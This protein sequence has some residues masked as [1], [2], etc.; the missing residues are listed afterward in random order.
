MIFYGLFFTHWLIVPCADSFFP[1][2]RSSS[3][4]FLLLFPSKE[5]WLNILEGH[6]KNTSEY[7]K[8]IL[9]S[10]L[11]YCLVLIKR[12]RV[13]IILL[14]WNVRHHSH[15]HHQPPPPKNKTK[16]NQYFLKLKFLL[17]KVV[18]SILIYDNQHNPPT[19]LPIIEHLLTCTSCKDSI[20][21]KVRSFLA[22][23]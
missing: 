11:F 13:G 1:F 5:R 21:K 10:I 23:Y 8:N 18:F 22:I 6:C 17:L 7:V 20:F 3:G 12:R 14:R 4:F 16:K 2:D 15:H 19:V 9:N